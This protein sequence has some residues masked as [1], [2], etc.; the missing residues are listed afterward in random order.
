MNAALKPGIY[1]P[2]GHLTRPRFLDFRCDLFGFC[3]IDRLRSRAGDLW[4]ARMNAKEDVRVY[5]SSPAL[6]LLG[7]IF[8]FM[9]AAL[10]ALLFPPWRTSG[11]NYGAGFLALAGVGCF[12]QAVRHRAD[13]K[14]AV[15][16]EA[17][18]VFRR[19]RTR[20]TLTY[21]DVRRDDWGYTPKYESP[22][23]DVFS[24][25]F[26]RLFSRRA[27]L[28]LYVGGR[29]TRNRVFIDGVGSRESLSLI[30]IQ[31]PSTTPAAVLQHQ[32][33]TPTVLLFPGDAIHVNV[34][35]RTLTTGATPTAETALTV[36]TDSAGATSI[37]P[38]GTQPLKI[39]GRKP[40]G[41]TVA[42][43][44][45][46]IRIGKHELVVRLL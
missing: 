21:G 17:L 33:G 8:C 7:G 43:A 46:D 36:H 15:G 23:D 35:G 40:E 37:D 16:R 31:A 27:G 28:F 4:E 22:G 38:T 32:S 34:A 20:C 14:V 6:Y 2:L 13:V 12:V 24:G 5:G 30:R 45:N 3:R 1:R 18:V 39:N 44:L 41:R 29:E 25:L 19:K 10:F 26:D 9:G 42:L 11:T